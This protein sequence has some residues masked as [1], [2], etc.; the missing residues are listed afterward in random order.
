[1]SAMPWVLGLAWGLLVWSAATQAVVGAVSAARARSLSRAAPGRNERKWP[2]A[3]RVPGAAR[4]VAAIST[5]RVAR[6]SRVAS[7]RVARELPVVVDLLG[8]GCAAGLT[9]YLAVEHAAR[10]GPPGLAASLAEVLRRHRLGIPFEKALTDVGRE[11]GS[12]ARGMFEILAAAARSGEPAVDPLERLAGDARADIRRRSE[13]R[14]RSL[15]VRLLF[16]LVFLVLPAFGLLVVVPTLIRGFAT[17][18]A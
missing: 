14:A 18:G 13:A 5:I 6:R 12:T 11:T 1:M 16:P 4:L 2:P 8:V 9:P 3:V 10:W 17:L 7:D 15:S